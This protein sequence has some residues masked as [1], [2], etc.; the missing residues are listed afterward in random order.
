M[1]EICLNGKE[2]IKFKNF[3]NNK[4]KSRAKFK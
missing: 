3:F 4:K 2:K 1:K